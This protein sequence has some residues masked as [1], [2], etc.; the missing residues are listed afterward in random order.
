V[1]GLG[2]TGRE[3]LAV[4]EARGHEAVP[5]RR[6]QAFPT[7][8]AA[9]IDFSHAEAVPGHV[10]AALATG[11]PYVVGTTGWERELP[12]LTRQVEQAGGALLHAANFSLGVNIFYRLVGD[13]ARRLAALPEYDPYVL[14]RHHR[15]KRDAPS[16]T[17]RVLAGLL[18]T[19][20]DGVRQPV[21]ALAGAALPDTAFHVASL[22]AGGIVGEH[23][24]GW[25]SGDD[26]LLLEHRARSRRGF[27]L[28]A[29]R[30]AEWLP[31]RRGVFTF[32]ALLDDLLAEARP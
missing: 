3:V 26:E 21:D 28:G 20:Y 23:V 29:V 10:A 24:V 17:A 7:G 12:A 6:D 16:G 19:A 4:L 8:C 22:R 31:G 5:V 1:V 11:T 15:H 14:E 27:A 25:D 18:A 32:E 9:G 13:A 2:R 30:A